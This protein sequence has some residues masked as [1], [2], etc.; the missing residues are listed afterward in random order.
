[1]QCTLMSA[2][3]SGLHYPYAILAQWSATRQK[4]QLTNTVGERIKTDWRLVIALHPTR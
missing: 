4:L 3:F 1:M 2:C